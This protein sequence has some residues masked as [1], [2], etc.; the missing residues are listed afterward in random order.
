MDE[1]SKW[2]FGSTRGNKKG[3]LWRNYRK[4]Q[5]QNLSPL[6]TSSFSPGVWTICSA[7]K[8]K[9]PRTSQPQNTYK[10]L[11]CEMCVLEK[12]C[13]P[14]KIPSNYGESEISSLYQSLKI[15]SFGVIN[16]FR[17]HVKDGAVSYLK[18]CSRYWDFLKSFLL[19]PLNGRADSVTWIS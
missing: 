16:T 6:T 11:L 14:D 17:D 8:L 9:S 10:S 19:T 18:I 13:R 3:Q 7:T 5:W 1:S 4:R 2:N 12:N 15:S